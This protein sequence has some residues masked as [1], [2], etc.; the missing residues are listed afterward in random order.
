MIR[1]NARM[2]KEIISRK[3]ALALG[4][5]RYFTGKPCKHGHISDRY[6]SGACAQC[7]GSASA[8]YYAANSEKLRA[9]RAAYS[10]AYYADNPEKARAA[11]AAWQ[12][13]HP[14]KLRAAAKKY[15]SNNPEKFA[16]NNSKRRA[17]KIAAMPESYT[18]FDEFVMQEAAE[19]CKRREAMTGY[20]WEVDHMTPL[21][22]GGLHHYTNIQVIPKS[23]NR[24]KGNRLIYTKPG[25]WVA[26]LPGA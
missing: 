9:T 23:I 24:S 15:Q 4:L 10:A 22:R 2:D 14:E 13:A 21:S 18:D 8:A 5:K 25:E 19:A 1:H 20:K 16:A 3:Q 12:K 7:I 17:T 26:T 6:V 11:T